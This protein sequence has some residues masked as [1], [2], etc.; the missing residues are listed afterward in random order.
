M[1]AARAVSVE[2]WPA[3]LARLSLRRLLVVF[4]GFFVLGQV[5]VIALASDGIRISQKGRAFNLKEI[6]VERGDVVHFG[7]DDEFIH[8]I[9]IKSSDFSFDSD[10]SMP[11][12]TIDVKF[13]KPGVYEVH[14]HIHP[15]MGLVVTVK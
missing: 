1:S 12:D 5:G 14:C 4:A 3:A 13:T 10:E 8:Q 2:R 11:G 7:N 15:K 9:F 6:T